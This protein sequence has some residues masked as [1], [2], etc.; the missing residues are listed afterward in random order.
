MAWLGRGARLVV[1][2]AGVVP[3]MG[4]VDD[5]SWESF[6]AA[7]NTD[8][9]ASFHVVKQALTLPLAPA[10]VRPMATAARMV[11]SR[12]MMG[13]PI[14]ATEGR[15]RTAGDTPPTDSIETS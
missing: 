2:S 7:W 8:L 9:K 12:R 3:A 5:F 13:L 15:H 10:A 4:T 11:R 6:S 1:L 14:R